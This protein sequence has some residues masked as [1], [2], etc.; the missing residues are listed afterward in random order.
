MARKAVTGSPVPRTEALCYAR[1]GG[2]SFGRVEGVGA[3]R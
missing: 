3:L 2:G 1:S